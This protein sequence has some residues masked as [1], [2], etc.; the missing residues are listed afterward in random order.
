M[1][2]FEANDAE[3]AAAVEA[4][5]EKITC[6]SAASA[7]LH[8]QCR[9]IPSSTVEWLQRL[10]AELFRPLH[11]ALR[12]EVMQSSYLQV[13]ETG[14]AVQDRAKQGTTHK[15]LHRGTRR[16]HLPPVILIRSIPTT[17]LDTYSLTL[18]TP[19][20]LTTE[21]YYPIVSI[22]QFKNRCTCWRAP[23]H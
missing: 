4:E 3:V 23:L 19:L 6:L 17:G 2:K 12:G 15:R 20:R 9:D 13:D 1:L 10:V 8:A 21:I 11:A 16:S 18:I 22:A 5:L 7:L 14:L